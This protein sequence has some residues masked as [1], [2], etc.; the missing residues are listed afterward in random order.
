MI[1]DFKN[2]LKLVSM[3]YD[4]G[5]HMGRISIMD[6]QVQKLI[7]SNA[8]FD[9]VISEI[10][11]NEIFLQFADHFNA[12]AIGFSTF[13]M[14][15]WTTGLVGN[16]KEYA[17]TPQSFLG[18]TDRMSFFERLVNTASTLLNEAFYNFKHLPRQE[19]LRKEIFPNGQSLY[20]RLN[21]VSLLLLN[22]HASLG[23]PKPLCPNVIE[24]G[25][26]HVGDP[27]PLP[28]DLQKLLD[29]ST[30]GVV[31]FSMGSN[32]QSKDFP[33]EHK[34]AILKTFGKLKE[35]VLWKFEA[36]LHDKPKNVIISKWFPQQDILGKVEEDRPEVE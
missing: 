3:L 30:Q 17:Y 33:D 15:E 26:F 10:F 4:F 28:N 19:E 11:M 1:E 36:D 7:K 20:Q 32:I 25:G 5:Y 8:K 23:T 14:S 22:S 27:N 31:Y 18:F 34:D 21:N 16:P 6:Q 12:H 13:G 29:D 2:P 35:T 24:I 9:V